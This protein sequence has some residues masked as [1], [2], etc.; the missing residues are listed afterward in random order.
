MC[1]RNVIIPSGFEYVLLHFP[2]NLKFY[3]IIMRKIMTGN[4][5]GLIMVRKEGWL[6][7]I[8]YHVQ[9]PLSRLC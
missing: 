4:V 7:E 3:R 1:V 2:V 6:A 8:P 5:G 9:T